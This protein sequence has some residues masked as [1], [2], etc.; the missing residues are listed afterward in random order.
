MKY[1]TDFLK[2]QPVLY[3]SIRYLVRLLRAIRNVTLNIDSMR[4]FNSWQCGLVDLGPGNFKFYSNIFP[5]LVEKIEDS[6]SSVTIIDVGAN[7]GWFAKVA[8]RFMGEGINVISFEPLRSMIPALKLLEERYKNF[9]YENVAIGAT[10]DEIEITEYVTSGLSSLKDLSSSYDYNK[11]HFDVEIS[12]KYRV[13]VISVDNYLSVHGIKTPIILKIDT[14]GFEFE[15]LNGAR[16]AFSSGQIKAVIIEVMTLEKYAGATL[17]QKIFDFLH[18]Y[19]F[20]L[21]DIHPSYYE[22]DGKLSEFD[23]AFLLQSAK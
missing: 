9:K 14:Q 20:S 1:L 5:R 11:D 13:Q 16:R 12:N 22:E 10:E 18:F 7:D 4:E 19:G 2:K 21:F 15:V 23:C 3:R 8:F 17:Y 6:F